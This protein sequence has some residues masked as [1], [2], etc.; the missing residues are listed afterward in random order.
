MPQYIDNILQTIVIL[1]CDPS[2]H[3]CNISGASDLAILL[4][5]IFEE[6]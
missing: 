2:K 3:Y 5:Y 4:Q 6:L 1:L